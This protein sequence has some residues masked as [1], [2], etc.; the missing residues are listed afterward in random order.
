MASF[1]RPIVHWTIFEWC[2]QTTGVGKEQEP[3]KSPM[4]IWVCLQDRLVWIHRRPVSS[5]CLELERR[6]LVQAPQRCVGSRHRCSRGLSVGLHFLS[7]ISGGGHIPSAF[8]TDA[9]T[10]SSTGDVALVSAAI[11]NFFAPDSEEPIEDLLFP[12][13]GST[14]DFPSDIAFYF[15][16]RIVASTDGS[17][18]VRITAG[19]VEVA[20]PSGQS[21]GVHVL[22][23]GSSV[24]VDPPT[25]LTYESEVSVIV[26]EGALLDMSGHETGLRETPLPT[27]MCV[28]MYTD[29]A[30]HNADAD[31][32][33]EG[34][35]DECWRW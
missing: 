11:F 12:I 15:N 22:A 16:E 27:Q 4:S 8:D 25:D 2:W 17:M 31:P 1:W 5:S 3:D 10:L 28:L 18:M 29:S 19:G 24:S 7:H 9:F 33:E 34:S 30:L 14:S 35:D 32:D 6:W 13:V 26:D 21:D 20:I 23:P